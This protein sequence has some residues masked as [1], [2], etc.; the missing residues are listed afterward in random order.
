M[1]GLSYHLDLLLGPTKLFSAIRQSP[2]VQGWPGLADPQLVAADQTISRQAQV[3]VLILILANLGPVE[4]SWAAHRRVL[5]AERMSVGG[6][7]PALSDNAGIEQRGVVASM[8]FQAT[9]L[10]MRLLGPGGRFLQDIW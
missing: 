2:I 9:S 7:I 10:R 3:A 6:A 8:G 5:Q 1:S 4:I